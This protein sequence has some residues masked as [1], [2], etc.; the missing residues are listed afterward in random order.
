MMCNKGEY[1]LHDSCYYSYLKGENSK[2]DIILFSL[3]Y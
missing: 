2:H 3:A 1:S